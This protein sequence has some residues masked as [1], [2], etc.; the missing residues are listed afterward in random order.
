[1]VLSIFREEATKGMRLV[2]RQAM[3]AVLV[4]GV[5][6]V[7]AMA[8]PARAQAPGPEYANEKLCQA[9]HKVVHGQS[10]A[11]TDNYLATKHA[12]ITGEGPRY[13]F[14]GQPGVG[15]QACHGPGTE[16]V[17]APMDQKL[18]TGKTPAE[19]ETRE[20]K[21]SLCGR[22]HGQYDEGF[23][24]DYK[25]GDNIL[26]KITLKAPTG[27]KLEQLNEMKDSKHFTSPTGP[28][29]IDCHTGHKALDPNLVPQLVA[30]I[31]DLCL[32]CHPA[33]AG[34]AHLTPLTQIPD[35]A[36]CATCH[37]PNKKHIFKVARQ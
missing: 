28:V 2:N 34:M 8:L 12:T 25:L 6:V 20:Q 19:L 1:M 36:T 9:C 22:C 29:C 18:A 3:A 15:C 33:N 27:G 14:N 17:K 30:P 21:L 5:A 31:D 7:V 35:G 13:N 16:H 4:V 26:D 24:A 32:K 11:V 10:P 37:M 23:V